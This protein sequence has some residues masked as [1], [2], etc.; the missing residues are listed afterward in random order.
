MLSLAIIKLMS[1]KDN[2]N[3][4]FVHFGLHALGVVPA[5]YFKTQLFIT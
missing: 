4:M 2:T 1:C 3:I 5:F